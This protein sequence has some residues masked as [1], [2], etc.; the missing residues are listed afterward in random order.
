M[1]H[2]AR[3]I[4]TVHSIS[5]Q[6]TQVGIKF[7]IAKSYC[8]FYILCIILLRGRTARCEVYQIFASKMKS[9]FQQEGFAK[10]AKNNGFLTFSSG[11][12][13]EILGLKVHP[14]FHFICL[15]L[16]NSFEQHNISEVMG[17]TFQAAQLTHERF[18]TMDHSCKI[19]F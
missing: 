9:F 1:D 3:E 17:K 8:P 19:F 15:T 7:T 5:A 13:R 16:L 12:L 4:S 6:T 10:Y 2:L 11:L 14:Y 18:L